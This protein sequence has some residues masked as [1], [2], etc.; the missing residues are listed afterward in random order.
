MTS[1][2]LSF[3]ILPLLFLPLNVTLFLLLE[4]IQ[5]YL[6]HPKFEIL[7]VVHVIL[8]HLQPAVLRSDSIRLLA[9]SVAT[10][11]QVALTTTW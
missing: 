8:I 5:R 10:S 7:K 9:R 2:A 3:L 1:H 4:N 11:R 6:V